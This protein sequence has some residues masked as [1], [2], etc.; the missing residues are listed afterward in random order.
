MS[1]FSEGALVF[2][3]GLLAGLTACGFFLKD[4]SDEDDDEDGTPQ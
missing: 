3:M 2:F 1:N 4:T